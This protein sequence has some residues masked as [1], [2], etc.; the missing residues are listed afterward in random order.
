MTMTG[1]VSLPDGVPRVNG[2][3]ERATGTFRGPLHKMVST[4]PTELWNDSC[5]AADLRSAIEDG[6]VGAT[7]NPTIVLGVV[8]QELEEWRGPIE[9]LFAKHPTDTEAQITWHL[10]EEMT[11]RAAALLRPIFERTGGAR[12]FI[13]LQTNPEYYKSTQ[14]LVTQALHFA[15][16]APNIQV[17]VPAT[18]IS[19]CRRS[20]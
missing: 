17:K 11:I 5:S 15:K 20:R 19:R 8:Q 10:I 13:S 12:G 2:A 16:L 6:A 3:P 4:T 18:A 7:S 1:V 9:D 14:A